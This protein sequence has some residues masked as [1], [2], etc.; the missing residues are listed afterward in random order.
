MSKNQ[1]TKPSQNN[2]EKQDRNKNKTEDRNDQD[3]FVCV[4][5]LFFFDISSVLRMRGCV[6]HVVERVLQQ[7]RSK[8]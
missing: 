1:N 8:Q 3:V 6:R 4:F 7:Q 5:K 2:A